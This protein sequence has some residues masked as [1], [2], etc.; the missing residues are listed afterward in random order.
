MWYFVDLSP[1]PGAGQP[2]V[3]SRPMR[4]LDALVLSALMALVRGAP[5]LV[6][7]VSNVDKT[8]LEIPE[9]F[10]RAE[11]EGDDTIERT[12]DRPLL[13]LIMSNSSRRKQLFDALADFHQFGMKK[14]GPITC[15]D[16]LDW[17]Q[18]AKCF[19]VLHAC[20]QATNEN[21][22]LMTT[23]LRV[24]DFVNDIFVDWTSDTPSPNRLDLFPDFEVE[25]KVVAGRICHHEK[26]HA[27]AAACIA[28]KSRCQILQ[29]VATYICRP[30][31]LNFDFQ[32]YDPEDDTCGP[33]PI[34]PVGASDLEW[35]K[36]D[37]A[38]KLKETIWKRIMKATHEHNKGLALL[39][40]R[41][42]I[43]WWSKGSPQDEMEMDMDAD[44]LNFL[45]RKDV[46]MVAVVHGKENYTYEFASDD[47]L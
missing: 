44:E 10:V 12:D 34:L 25:A 38:V 42:L 47:E 2:V 41:K 33:G 21:A 30:G 17:T 39:Q 32:W 19:D 40:V 36:T 43:R 14:G 6:F 27:S 29:A 3:L 1:A 7:G 24:D 5:P 8:T 18:L 9:G 31:Q 22:S 23:R 37:W 11:F 26:T 16:D 20:R 46:E 28:A 15:A 13:V 4:S 45:G 35:E